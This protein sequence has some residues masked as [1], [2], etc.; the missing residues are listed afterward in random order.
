MSMFE[1]KPIEASELPAALARIE[2]MTERAIARAS[3]P[4]ADVSKQ[5]QALSRLITETL[6]VTVRTSEGLPSGEPGGWG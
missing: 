6:T 5:M 2:R 3:K 4:G 1:T